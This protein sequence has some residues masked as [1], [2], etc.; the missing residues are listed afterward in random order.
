[1]DEKIPEDHGHNP[2]FT[3]DTLDAELSATSRPADCPP[4]LEYLLQV[5]Q[6]LVKQQIELIEVISDFEAE[7]KYK[8]IIN[9]HLFSAI[10]D[11]YFKVLNTMGQQVYFAVE[12]S[13]CL[14]RQCCGSIRDF[15]MS[16]LDNNGAEVA[17]F[18]RPFKTTCRCF[19]CFCPFCLQ[20]MEITSGGAVVGYVIQIQERDSMVVPHPLLSFNQSDGPWIH[21]KD[22]C[23][24][25]FKICDADKNPLLF[26][27]GPIINCS[28][29]KE[30]FNGL[31]IRL[32][33]QVGSYNS[34]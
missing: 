30:Q 11:D 25:I 20:E 19:T 22:Y 33:F 26:I 32:S 18:H 27:R 24:P 14:Q 10:F 21:D 34:P 12:H 5:D 23:R 31:L 15:E 28:C 1:M 13:S 4:G 17:R 7:N 8:V 16:I 6:L 2:A 9:S 29:C 3:D